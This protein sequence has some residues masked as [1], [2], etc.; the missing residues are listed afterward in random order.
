ML[1]E[2]LLRQI[3]RK[4]DEILARPDLPYWINLKEA[5][6]LKGLSYST[7]TNQ[8]HLQPRHGVP[9]DWF[10][11]RKVWRKTTILEWLEETDSPRQEVQ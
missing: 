4:L 1:D 7:A 9:D 11:H 5:C 10:L 8:P 2:E 3:N 6:R